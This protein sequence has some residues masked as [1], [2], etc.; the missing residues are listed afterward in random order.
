MFHVYIY[1]NTFRWGGGCSGW[2]ISRWHITDKAFDLFKMILVRRSSYAIRFFYLKFW[3]HIMDNGRIL[4]SNC[5]V[6]MFSHQ[7]ECWRNAYIHSHMT[8]VTQYLY[9]S[10]ICLNYVYLYRDWTR[11]CM[12]YLSYN[13]YQILY[14]FIEINIFGS[15]GDDHF[16]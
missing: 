1:N 4:T 15:F 8:Y 12:N 7:Q 9:L 10:C 3:L 11:V 14:A 13:A 16:L 6:P 2:R 5:K